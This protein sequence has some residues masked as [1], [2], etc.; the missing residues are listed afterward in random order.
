MA[1]LAWEDWKRVTGL[2]WHLL[3]LAAA[4]VLN[5]AALRVRT[6]VHGCETRQAAVL[7][8]GLNSSFQ[9]APSWD[10]SCPRCCLV[11]SL[12]LWLSGAGGNANF[13]YGMNLLWGGQ[14]VLLLLRLL[15][16]A[17]RSEADS[18]RAADGQTDRRHLQ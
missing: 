9:A 14:L 16:G 1:P 10:G 17:A 6:V 2:A 15:R 7:V 11:P 5:D 3:G 12:Q 18:R 8:H 13:L 4:L